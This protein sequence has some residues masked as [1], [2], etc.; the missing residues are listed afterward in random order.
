VYFH[1]GV[2]F[3]AEGRSGYTSAVASP[4]LEA[5]AKY[6]VTS[7]ALVPYGFTRRG[8]PEVRFGGGWETDE[9]IE[10]V[11][12]A[13]HRLGMK[14]MLKP[15]LW[16]RPGYPGDL[17]FPDPAEREK[18]F[19]GYQS[20]IEHQAR[21][22]TL[23]HADILC[24]GVEFAKLTR[25]E[26]NWRKLIART[27]EV[28]AGPLVYASTHGEEFERIRFWDTLDYIGINEYSPLPDSLST[29]A[30]V[31]RIKAVQQR[32]RKP[33]IFP[34][35]GFASLE[36]PQREP[37]NE[38]RRKLSMED[39]ARCYEAILKAF[40]R[41]PWF[42]GMYWWKV[43]TNGYG[44]AEDGSHTPWRKPSMEVVRRWYRE[45]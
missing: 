26:S 40:Y 39:Q 20:Y 30:L 44:G 6:G 19:A 35:I 16:V 13:A 12:A 33:V 11:A 14:V 27:R 9:G 32:F 43:G 2:N 3:T 10:Q 28:Y 23:I 38:T 42:Q 1:K 4:T 24:I 41:Q 21:R 5:L 18:W 17:D 36:N 29:D 22:A 25:Y 31:A 37:W 34:E 8:T 45:R 7:I 15:Q